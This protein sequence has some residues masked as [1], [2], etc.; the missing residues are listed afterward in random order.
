MTI[1]KQPSGRFYAVLKAGRS[2]VAGRTFDTKRAAQAWLARE[3]AALAGGVDPRAGRATVRTLLPVWL[4]ERKHSVSAKTYTADAALP[5]L[6]P[7]ALGA[8]S[9]NAVTDREI[10]RALIILTKSGLAESSVRRFRDS[11][12]SFF[13]WAV[14]ERMIAAN[15]V[16]PTRVPRAGT[17]RVEMF[18]FGHFW[19]VRQ[20]DVYAAGANVA[21]LGAEMAHQT[22]PGEACPDAILNLG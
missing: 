16:M 5:R 12:S 20:Q 8:L 9:I 17:P 14:R 1:R 15:P 6:V 18:P 11:L 4:D 22:L 2:Y 7:T 10:T 21:E 13:A 19:A 3:R